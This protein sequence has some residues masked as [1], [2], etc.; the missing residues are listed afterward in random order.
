MKWKSFGPT[1]GCVTNPRDVHIEI[2]P[3][4]ASNSSQRFVDQ[5]IWKSS[6][7]VSNYSNSQ[8]SGECLELGLIYETE[9]FLVHLER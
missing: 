9:A 3:V 5:Y 1:L 8:N 7:L 2:K 6:L 4:M